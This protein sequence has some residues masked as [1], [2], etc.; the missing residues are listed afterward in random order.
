MVGVRIS[1]ARYGRGAAAVLPPLLPQPNELG[2]FFS[3]LLAKW[4]IQW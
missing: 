2:F 4:C 3:F 1:F